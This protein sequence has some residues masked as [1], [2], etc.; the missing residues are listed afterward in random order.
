MFHFEISGKEDNLEQSVN[1]YLIF[2]TEEVSHLEMSGK[3][4]IS[5]QLK[6]I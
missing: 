3:E 2:F 4:H 1:I 6:N 5:K